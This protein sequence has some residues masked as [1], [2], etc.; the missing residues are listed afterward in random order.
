M[1]EG[2]LLDLAYRS[3]AV[4]KP[5][6]SPRRSFLPHPVPSSM[7]SDVSVTRVVGTTS[8]LRSHAQVIA[9]IAHA[10][11]PIVSQSQCAVWMLRDCLRTKHSSSSVLKAPISDFSHQPAYSTILHFCYIEISTSKTSG[12]DTTHM[13]PS[14]RNAFKLCLESILNNSFSNPRKHTSTPIALQHSRSMSGV[15]I[16]E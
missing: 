5:I 1:R 16:H 8:S 9:E 13:Y 2:R 11:L 14:F 7:Q 6:L 4:H 3:V 12:S 15:G 10:K